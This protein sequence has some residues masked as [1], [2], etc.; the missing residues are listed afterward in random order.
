[1]RGLFGFPWIRSMEVG[2]VNIFHFDEGNTH[3]GER[4]RT[5][6][7]I[8]HRIR[9][10]DIWLTS[11]LVFPVVKQSR[12]RDFRGSDAQA[13]T[14]YPPLV[15]QYSC[16][17][18]RR[19]WDAYVSVLHVL[20]PIAH[21]FRHQLLVVSGL[22]GC[23]ATNAF[24]PSIPNL[25]H[26]PCGAFQPCVLPLSKRR[27]LSIPL[28]DE[29]GTATWSLRRCTLQQKSAESRINFDTH[30]PCLGTG[31]GEGKASKEAEAGGAEGPPGVGNG[32]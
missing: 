15:L 21:S 23:A 31:A 30:G 10:T 13:V 17:F 3:V 22:R 14:L 26:K 24:Q 25:A 19:Y 7:T 28:K 29:K 6:V 18:F 12:T 8:S 16:F 5:V 32:G 20:C 9:Q 11:R 27:S 2:T 1:M 4:W